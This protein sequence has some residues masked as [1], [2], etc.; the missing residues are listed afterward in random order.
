[1]EE[2][3]VPPSFK[4]I[5][6]DTFVTSGNTT[7]FECIVAGKPTPKVSVHNKEI[8]GN[9]FVILIFFGGEIKQ[10]LI[11]KVIKSFQILY[12]ICFS[13]V[14]TITIYGDWCYS[15]LVGCQKFSSKYVRRLFRYSFMLV[16]FG[17]QVGI[18]V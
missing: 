3:L 10:D 8:K 1:M 17:N 15:N 6:S 14:F 7:K 5:F 18:I 12:Y 4:E 11:D 16:P 2:K 9:S 13:L